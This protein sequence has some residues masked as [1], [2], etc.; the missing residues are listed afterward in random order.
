M[1][2]NASLDICCMDADVSVLLIRKLLI[3]KLMR[4]CLFCSVIR[5]IL[6]VC[7]AKDDDFWT[8]KIR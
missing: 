4:T 6:S 1:I 8:E 7:E 3:R 2:E 5:K